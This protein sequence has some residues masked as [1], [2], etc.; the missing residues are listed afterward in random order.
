MGVLVK[1]AQWVESRIDLARRRFEPRFRLKLRE[2]KTE[3]LEVKRRIPKLSALSG[4][5]LQLRASLLKVDAR[6]RMM[7]SELIGRVIVE[8]EKVRRTLPRE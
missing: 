4:A 5:E 7:I 1:T 3:W 8:L 2:A 6:L